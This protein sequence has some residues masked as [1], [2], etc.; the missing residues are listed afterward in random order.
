MLLV[1]AKFRWNAAKR[2]ARP[3]FKYRRGFPD[4][5]KTCASRV[6]F[7]TT[8]P[9]REFARKRERFVVR[10]FERTIKRFFLINIV[11]LEFLNYLPTFEFKKIF[12]LIF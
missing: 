3:R 12:C 4:A 11:S 8:I 9:K 10:V 5:C 1:D 2:K 6:F 7:F